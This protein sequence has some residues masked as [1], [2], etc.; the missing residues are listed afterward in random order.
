MN[1]INGGEHADNNI[2]LQE[3]MIMP[4]EQLPSEGLRWGIET[5]H[6]L[7]SVL[8]DRGSPLWSETKADSLPISPATKKL[9]LLVEAI[10]KAGF[11]PGQEIALTIDAAAWLL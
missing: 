5:Y 4:V 6:V 2:D 9:A 7:K 11:A 1:V 3:F 8:N 10:E